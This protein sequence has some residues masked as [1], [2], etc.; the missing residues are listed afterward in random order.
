MTA[1]DELKDPAEVARRRGKELRELV[2]ASRI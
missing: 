2:P 1:L